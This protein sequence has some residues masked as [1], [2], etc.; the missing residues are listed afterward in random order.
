[1]ANNLNLTCDCRWCVFVLLFVGI[2][3]QSQEIWN[4]LTVY[5]ATVE[6]VIFKTSTFCNPTI[7]SQASSSI[8]LLW[9]DRIS[10]PAVNCQSNAKLAHLQELLVHTF[11]SWAGIKYFPEK[12]FFSISCQVRVNKYPIYINRFN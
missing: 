9:R 5:N 8:P 1:M 3:L 11:P 10:Q 4:A 2:C 7:L 6:K 12:P